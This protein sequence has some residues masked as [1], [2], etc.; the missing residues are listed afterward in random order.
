MSMRVLRLFQPQPTLS[1][2]E[3]S[4]GLSMMTLEGMA[5]NG[6]SG[7]TT[8]GFLVAFALALGANN[9]QIGILAAIPFILQ[10]IQI[11]TILLVEKLRWRKAIAVST[12]T[13]AQLL[14]FPMALI[15]VFTKVPGAGAISLLLVIMAVRSV[16]SA[17]TNCSWNSWVRDLVPRGILGRFFGRRLALSTAVAAVFVL[18][19]AFFVDYWGGQVPQESAI[20]GYTYALLFGAFFLGLASPLFMSFQPEPLM[21]T[22]MGDQPSL[23]KMVIMPLRDRNFRQLM[24]FLLFWS[25]ALNIAVPFFAVYMLKQLGLSL[26][27]VIGLSVLGQFFNIL[28]LRVWGPLVD[29]FGSKAVL[30]L[31]ASLYLLVILG[32]TFTGI[33]ERY[34]LTFPLLIILNIFAGIAGA[35]VSL[36]IGTI[37]FKLAPQ[38]RSASYLAGASLATNLGTGIGPLLGGLLASFFSSRKLTLDLTWID[39]HKMIHLGVINLAGFDFLFI[40][41]FIVGL[42]TL[43]MLAALREEGEA[44][45]EVVL[46]E[47]RSRTRSTLRSVISVTSPNFVNMFPLSF[48][49]R[50]PGMDVAIGVTAYQLADTAKAVTVAALHGGR[51]AMKVARALQDGLDRL[52]ETGTAPPQHDSEV[53]RQA[54]RGALHAAD[55]APVGNENLAGPAVIGIV[56]ALDEAHVNPYDAI[57]GAAY[58]V[59]EGA[60]ETGTDLGRA[61][62]DAINGARETAKELNL[63]EGEA[64]QQAG[65]GAL[66]AAQKFGSSAVARITEVL[67][68]ELTADRSTPEKDK[69]DDKSAGE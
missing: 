37:G 44:G 40:L 39:P 30:S 27:T 15:P 29:R 6:F 2:K 4:R 34:F 45:K 1:D 5:S 7:I 62:T 35:G 48:L 59:V 21:Q 25:I 11:P 43:N 9:F 26:S 55:E 46:G 23:W 50:V 24:R 69:G 3:V 64:V 33:P 52:W 49:N 10:L 67:S 56:R 19:A 20:L 57:R 14:W 60:K 13:V 54:A 63:K 12:W 8:S 41:T 65:R 36:T 66:N 31:S 32:F 38:E 17:V 68:E 42:I 18:G 51:T 22:A 47:L 53:A 61:A 16:F 58:G 28:F